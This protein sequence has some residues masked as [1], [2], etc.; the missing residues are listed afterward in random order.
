MRTRIS[1]IFTE[2][3]SDYIHENSCPLVKRGH[4]ISNDS[5]Y[6]GCLGGNHGGVVAACL[7][8]LFSVSLYE[9]PRVVSTVKSNSSALN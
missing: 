7:F 3:R 6:R 9:G 8:Y 2:Q 4:G 1:R 5:S